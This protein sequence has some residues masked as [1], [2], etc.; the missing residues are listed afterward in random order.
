MEAPEVPL[1]QVQEHIEHHAHN[2]QEK[3]VSWVAL[4]TAILAAFAAVAALLAGDHANEAMI[5]QIKSSDKWSHYQSKSIKKLVLKSKLDLLAAQGHQADGKDREKLA[6]YDKDQDE[7]QVEAKQEGEEA[8]EHLHKHVRMAR[9]VT[10]FQI[11]ITI[12]AIAVL[13]K[14]HAFWFVGLAFGA[15]G[16]F[17]LLL[18]LLH[19]A[20]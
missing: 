10:M 17:F 9:G 15:A 3:W 12:S 5:S 8:E 20:T 18:G 19:H 7:I 13:T 4:S 2:S 14:R 6:E 16:I 1:E 11:A